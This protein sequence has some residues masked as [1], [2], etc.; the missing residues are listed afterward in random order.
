MFIIVFHPLWWR[1]S[2]W[3]CCNNIV[4]ITWSCAVVHYEARVE[5]DRDISRSCRSRVTNTCLKHWRS[6]SNIEPA[7]LPRCP[8]L[9]WGSGAQ[10]RLS[11]VPYTSLLTLKT[12]CVINPH[13]LVMVKQRR[14]VMFLP[15][16]YCD[17]D[18]IFQWLYSNFVV[19]ASTI[20]V[21]C[22][23]K[24]KKNLSFQCSLLDVV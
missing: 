8:C 1:V 11:P 19:F 21:A 7:A 5:G 18:F 13:S 12:C 15:T 16:S 3:V 23:N 2:I 10:T 4:V 6:E 22:F 14:V 20:F 24:C 17:L 9:P